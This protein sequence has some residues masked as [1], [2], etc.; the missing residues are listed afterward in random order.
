MSSNV[1]LPANETRVLQVLASYDWNNLQT[2]KAENQTLDDDARQRETHTVFIQAGYGF[3][4]QWSLDV[5]LPWV[6]QERTVFAEN[7][8]REMTHSEGLGDVVIL[9]KYKIH[10]NWTTDRKSVV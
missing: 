9:P 6:R 3:N 4:E 1:G 10:K 8:T 2:L 5:F 7:G